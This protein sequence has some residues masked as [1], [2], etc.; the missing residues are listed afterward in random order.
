LYGLAAP[1]GVHG[2]GVDR[3]LDRDVGEW[4]RF[5]LMLM[6]MLMLTRR[7]VERDRRA[8]QPRCGARD[9]AHLLHRYAGRVDLGG[10]GVGQ[11]ADDQNPCG[12]AGLPGVGRLGCGDF[13]DQPGVARFSPCRGGA[14]RRFGQRGEGGLQ[15][16]AAELIRRH[17]LA[18]DFRGNAVGREDRAMR[19]PLKFA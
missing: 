17:D 5:L 18:N 12:D 7:A 15:E 6:L 4:H 19:L 14:G 1:G 9:T 13:L 10:D 3:F 2:G 16:V 8:Q 11:V